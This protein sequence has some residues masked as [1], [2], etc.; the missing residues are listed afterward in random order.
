MIL[1][2][3]I[4]DG[5]LLSIAKGRSRPQRRS[6]CCASEFPPRFWSSCSAGGGSTAMV[7]FS[8]KKSKSKRKKRPR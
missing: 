4:P 1:V 3:M 6:Y 7:P 5:G 2:D 8:N